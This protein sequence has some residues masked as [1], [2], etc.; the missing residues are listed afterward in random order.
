[1]KRIKRRKNLDFDYEKRRMPLSLIVTE[2]TADEYDKKDLKT[3]AA[4]FL[5]NGVPEFSVNEQNGE[6]RLLAA[7]RDYFAVKM[8]GAT[9]AEVRIYQFPLPSLPP[10]QELPGLSQSGEASSRPWSV[11]ERLLI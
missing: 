11:T 7:E 3:R 8:I 9:D 5:L 2:R 6:Y 4:Y 1:M 10:G